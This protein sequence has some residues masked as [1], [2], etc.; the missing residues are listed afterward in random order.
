MAGRVV[1]VWPPHLGVAAYNILTRLTVSAPATSCKRQRRSVRGRRRRGRRTARAGWRVA[2]AQRTWQLLLCSY[3][4][5]RSEPQID[6]RSKSGSTCNALGATRQARCMW[7]VRGSGPGRGDGRPSAQGR[8]TGAGGAVRGRREPRL[9]VAS[10][11]PHGAPNHLR[12]G[13]PAANGLSVDSGR[14]MVPPGGTASPRVREPTSFLRT[15]ATSGAD[16]VGT[17]PGHQRILQPGHG[18]ASHPS[19][20]LVLPFFHF[21]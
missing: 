6:K 20:N 17:L 12:D 4:T 1:Q 14:S 16:G 3:R 15:P 21:R 9:S 5:T 13:S 11:T 19:I 18:R 2:K 8:E 10:A 7:V